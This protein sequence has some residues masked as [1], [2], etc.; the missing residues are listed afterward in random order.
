MPITVTCQCKK[1]FQ[2]PELLAGKTVK[3]PN[4]ASPLTI[5][6]PAAQ[7]DLFDDLADLAAAAEFAPSADHR[8]GG[9][10]GGLGSPLQLHRPSKSLP[11]VPIVGGGIA[12]VAVLIVLLV[13]F[14]GGGGEGRR[15]AE[16]NAP[17]SGPS[18]PAEAANGSSRS[19]GARDNSAATVRPRPKRTTP[20]PTA[21]GPAPQASGQ[22]NGAS[23][24][25]SL[26]GDI[27]SAIAR[28][29]TGGSSTSEQSVNSN[30]SGHLDPKLRPALLQWHSGGKLTST[31]RSGDSDM[32]ELHYGWMVGLL[33]H[34]GYQD[35]YDKFDFEKPW[36]DEANLEHAS[37]EIPEFL[38]PADSRKEYE[39]YRYTGMALTHFVGVSGVEDRR[40][41]V[42]AALPRSD[43]RA[44][45]FGYED[46]AAPREI[47]DGTSRT[48]MMIGSGE[49]ACPWVQSGGSTIRGAR[50]P[51]FGD[52]TGFGTNGG[53]GKGAIA[54]MAD[55]SVR[56]INADVD[57][58]VFR[59]MCTING[60]D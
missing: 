47:K 25:S 49:L 23:P 51:Y 28:R 44:G 55:G 33:P 36:H 27:G 26:F 17:Q 4:C 1:S 59:A 39:G 16:N 21:G 53:P 11:W 56:W 7:D 45:I 22:V 46:I 54:V 34:L 6:R 31:R 15:T 38:N 20:S 52:L 8:L 32:H 43:P 29:L 41:V 19:D 12:A 5:P 10:G 40:N 9:S 2:A 37:R 13:V 35:H 58:Q 48:L 42:A 3:C 60:G 57:P 24:G 14:L 30:L 50:Q 18:Q